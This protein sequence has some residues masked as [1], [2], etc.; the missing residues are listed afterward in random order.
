MALAHAYRTLSQQPAPTH[1]P[2]HLE[3]APR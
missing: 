3:T 2:A 1:E